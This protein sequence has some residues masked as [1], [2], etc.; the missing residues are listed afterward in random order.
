MSYDNASAFQQNTAPSYSSGYLTHHQ[1]NMSEVYAAD[2][3]ILD[4]KGSNLRWSVSSDSAVTESLQ[5]AQQNSEA[6][7]ASQ[8]KTYTE[9]LAAQGRSMYDLSSHLSQAQNYSEGVSERE[10]FDVQESARYL[11]SEASAFAQQ[12]G[13]SE[14]EGM[15]LLLGGN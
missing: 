7:T 13:I 2:E 10:A 15:S 14:H 4:H 11:K 1:G 12:Y 8:Q 9:S 5:K 3:V 6:F